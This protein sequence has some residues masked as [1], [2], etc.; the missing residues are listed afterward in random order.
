[1]S[2]QGKFG[3]R[4][5]LVSVLDVT[6]SAARSGRGPEEYN[7]L[8][9]I[10]L[11]RRG[12]FTVELHD[13]TLLLDPGSALVLAGDETFRVGHPVDGG[14]RCTVL[15]FAPD[16]VEEALGDAKTRVVRIGPSREADDDEE[17]ILLLE[18]VARAPEPRVTRV[19][20]RR[21]A[22]VREL[23]AADPGAEWRLEKIA[24]ALHCSPYHLARQFRN[25]TGT[26]IAA[27]LM[28]LRLTLALERLEQG[29]DDLARL[30]ADL[31]FASHSHFTARFRRRLGC[32]P[33]HL[34]KTVTAESANAA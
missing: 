31:G 18:K 27:H 15:R 17:A 19:S 4:S 1:V 11:V 8:T 28:D 16:L 5:R 32:V 33:S 7:E 2:L 9:D 34:R 23:L 6:C 10:A 26:T 3:F 14:D 24:T 13:E 20:E 12:V 21:A 30:A 29:E 22:E 25:A